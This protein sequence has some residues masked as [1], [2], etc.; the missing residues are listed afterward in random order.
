MSYPR[1]EIERAEDPDGTWLSL[2][3]RMK[4]DLAGM[5]ISLADWK[6]LSV[7]TQTELEQAS[8]EEE[9]T[10]Q[11]FARRLETS[12][13][14]TG[15]S[16]RPLPPDKLRAVEKW[17]SP[18]PEPVEVTAAREGAGEVPLWDHLDRFGRY[19][20]YSLASRGKRQKFARAARELSA[21]LPHPGSHP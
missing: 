15:K 2:G 4:L 5:Q 21:S 1:L 13:Q 18:G 7:A 11:T 10:I 20:L 6:A 9:A 8:G 3:M 19:V 12:L 17:K 14:T 16:C